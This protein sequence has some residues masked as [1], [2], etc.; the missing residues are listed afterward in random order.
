VVNDT[1]QRS[2][3]IEGLEFISQLVRR[4]TEIERIYLQGEEPALRNDLEAAIMKLYRQILEYEARAACQFNRNTAFQIARNIVGADSWESILD[5]IKTSEVACDGLK[6]VIDAE[7]QRV[8][9]RRLGNMLEKQARKVDE[10][11]KVSRGQDEELLAEIKAMRKDQK[12]SFE[13]QEE[14]DCHKSLRTT[15]YEDT[16]EKN[17]DRV[18]GTCEWF[19]QNP[20]YCKWLNDTA[21]DLLWVTADP[22]CGKSVLS[23]F[24]INDYKS[25]MWKDTSVCYFFFKDDS[26]ENRSATYALCAILHQLF[27]QNHALLK[28]AMAEYNSN[29]TKLPLLFGSLWSILLQAA[30]DSSSDRIFCIIDALDECAESSCEQLIKCLAEFHSNVNRTTKIKFLITSRPNSFIRRVFSEN[31]SQ[32]NQDLASVKLMGENELEM[33]EICAEIDLVI[34]AKV[35]DFKKERFSS[36]GIDDNADVAVREQLKNIE[37]RTYLWMALVFPELKKMIEYAEDELLK[38]VKRIP[39]T[40]DE[41]YEK[42]LS[43]STDGKKARRLLHIVCAAS[44]PLTLTEMNRALSIKENGC[45]AALVP[46]Q[47]FGNVVRDLCGLFISIQHKRIYLIHQTAKEFLIHEN[48]IEEPISPVS[49][50]NESWKHSLG[51]TESNLVLA[52]ICIRYL[53]FSELKNDSLVLDEIKVWDIE[54]QVEEDVTKHDLLDYSAKHWATHFRKAKSEQRTILELAL[55]NC[56]TRSKRFITWFQ[57]YWTTTGFHS[58]PPSNF[59]DLMV[60]SYFGH[61]AVVKQLLERGVD[62]NSKDNKYGQTPLSWAAGNGH[63]EVVK[64]LLAKADVDPDPKDNNGQTPLSRAAGNGHQEVVKLLLAKADVN[65]DPKD[66]NGQTPLSR[67]AEMGQEEVV[68]LLLAKADVN[69][70]PKDNDGQTPLSWAAGNGRQEV[71]KLLLA[72]ADVDPDP[73]D[74][75]NQTPLWWAAGNGHQEVVKLLLAKASVD[76]DSKDNNGQTPL[77]LA[78]GNGHEEVAKLLLAKDGGT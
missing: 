65:P 61:E 72:K 41:A 34:D 77:S 64:L 2:A 3:A 33:E 50:G 45:F 51:P 73:K 9:M 54:K 68:K 22:G 32:Y 6:E 25:W 44:R 4:Y 58:R 70:D 78:A 15:T 31:F 76:P 29:G 19:L 53:L 36:Y 7:D 28:H 69:P 39:S 17:P 52:E 55:E 48:A 26:G 11:L 12:A 59:T 71:V 74:N 13:T 27:I 18:S 56:D 42:I 66:N 63:E 20:R 75:N 23:K 67:A 5:N 60:G 24:L 8:R 62:P 30:A 40:V 49:S 38:A 47:S 14:M 1:K 10:L 21:S 46:S 37:N 16:M 43:K 57:V 35:K